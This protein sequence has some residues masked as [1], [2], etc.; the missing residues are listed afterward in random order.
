MG[1][2]D[3]QSTHKY[4]EMSIDGRNASI[5]PIMRRDMTAF[6]QIKPCATRDDITGRS[7]C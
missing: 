1:E 6:H 3:R 5:V 2:D 7:H 4:A